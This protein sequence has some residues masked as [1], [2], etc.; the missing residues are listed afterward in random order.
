MEAELVSLAELIL[1]R[2][3]TRLAAEILKT[4]VSFSFDC[5]HHEWSLDDY[6]ELVESLSYAF[7]P[8]QSKRLK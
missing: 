6:A 5:E 4:T 7:T 8:S 2:K 1:C 3:L